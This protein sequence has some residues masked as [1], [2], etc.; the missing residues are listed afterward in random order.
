MGL[1]GSPQDAGNLADK[2]AR[3]LVDSAPDSLLDLYN[4][5]RRTVAVDLVQQQSAP[6]TRVAA[7]TLE[8]A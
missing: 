2:R 6:Q 8:A 5:Q 7:L 3:V 1:N 4:R